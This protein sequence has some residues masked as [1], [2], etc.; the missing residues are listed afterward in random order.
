MVTLHNTNTKHLI[1][2]NGYV[3]NLSLEK[4]LNFVETSVSDPSDHRKDLCA[5]CMRLT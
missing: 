3:L 5:P 1:N 4:P 2:E